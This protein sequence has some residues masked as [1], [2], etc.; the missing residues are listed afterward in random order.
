MK[1]PVLAVI[2]SGCGHLD[3]S[4][5]HEAT[6]TLLAIHKHNADYICFAP[7]KD[8]THVINH[9][10]GEVV[11]ETRNVLVE[12]AR[13]ARGNI[14][15][16]SEFDSGMFDGII[17]PGGFGAAKNLSNY[18]MTGIDCEVDQEVADAIL[19]MHNNGKPVGALC[20]AP[21]V[22]ARLIPNAG[23]T[24]GDDIHTAN[25]L[26][27]MG[28]THHNTSHG[29]IYIDREKKLVTTPCY[30]LDS[31]VDQIAAGAEKLVEAVLGIRD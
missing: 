16:M 9:C 19:S 10:T 14:K 15:P 2:L 8:Q 5:I 4:E 21:V 23:L 27:T 12:S 6:L 7:D 20:I 18:A 25:N 31:R 26:V 24:I 22:L 29:E 1:R 11:P 3:G 30:M 28:A 13:I 17:L